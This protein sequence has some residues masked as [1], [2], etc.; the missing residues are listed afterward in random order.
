MLAVDPSSPFSGGALL[1]DLVRMQD[2]ATDG[3]VFIRSMAT[4]GFLGGLA[5]ATNDVVDLLDA[6]RV[7]VVLVD[8]EGYDWEVLRSIDLDPVRPRLLVYEHFHLDA[9]DRVAC[10]EHLERHGYET[11]EEGFDTWCL[12]PRPDDPLTV[13]WRRLRPGVPGVSVHDEAP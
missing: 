11:M 4:R 13:F 3:G 6:E 5:K 2:H 12:E 10:R 7:D 8:T 9:G 1:G